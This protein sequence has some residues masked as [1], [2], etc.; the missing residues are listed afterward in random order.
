MWHIRPVVCFRRLRSNG[1]GSDGPAMNYYNDHDPF[2]CGWLKELVAA[3]LLPEG[4]VDNRSIA[5]D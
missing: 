3:G 2:C 1:R 4:D 5:D